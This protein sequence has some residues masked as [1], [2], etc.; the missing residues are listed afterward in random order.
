ML[1]D[2][3]P[4]KAE[5]AQTMEVGG[6]PQDGQKRRSLARARTLPSGTGP[7]SPTGTAP[8]RANYGDH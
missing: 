7:P 6:V 8:G 2:T 4:A 3:Q 1:G 5:V